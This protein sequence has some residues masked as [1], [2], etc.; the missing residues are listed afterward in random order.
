MASLSN[1]VWRKKRGRSSP[2]DSNLTQHDIL[3]DLKST[4][5][6]PTGGSAQMAGFQSIASYNWLN[7]SEPT[8]LIPGM[9]HALE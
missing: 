9:A 6:V 8:I 1:Y 7:S 5:I 4:D 2:P 3:L